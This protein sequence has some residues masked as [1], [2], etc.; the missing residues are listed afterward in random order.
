MLNPIELQ[1]FIERTK[2][3]VEKAKKLQGDNYNDKFF[4]VDLKEKKP[5]R[6]VQQNAYLWVT[7]TYVALEE[8]YPKDT[9]EGFFKDVNKDIFL[10]RGRNKRGETFRYYRHINELDK[11]E[12][13]ICIDRWLHHCSMVRG[14]YIPSPEDHYYMVWQMQ[15]ERDAEL[16]KELL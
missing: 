8:G 1:R 12:M 10:R 5:T 4:V 2:A 14:I 9:V 15:V 11:E 6:T 7:I 3:M 13:S 16:N